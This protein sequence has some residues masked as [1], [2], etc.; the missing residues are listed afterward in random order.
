MTGDVLK[1]SPTFVALLSLFLGACE[2]SDKQTTKTS[3]NDTEIEA[4]N[5]EISNTGASADNLSLVEVG[6]SDD[7]RVVEPFGVIV[8]D[9]IWQFDPGEPKIIVICWKGPNEAFSEEKAL[10]RETIDETWGQASALRFVYWGECKADISPAVRVRLADHK[11]SPYAYALG[12]KLYDFGHKGLYLNVEWTVHHEEWGDDWP[13]ENCT[14]PGNRINCI[15]ASAIHEFGH[16]AGIHHEQKHP[17]APSECKEQFE[18]ADQTELGPDEAAVTPFDPMSVM[19]YCRRDRMTA[20]TLSELDKK[21]MELL[22]CRKGEPN[23]PGYSKRA[24]SH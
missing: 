21:T 19:N 7:P 5:V 16:V 6:D 9:A 22:Y 8:E 4:T 18:R 11:R 1:I 14:S 24:I 17:E 12:R 20:L 15:K 3:E 2:G 10:I 13:F 23:C